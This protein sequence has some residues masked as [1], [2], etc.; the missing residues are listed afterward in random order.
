MPRVLGFLRQK[1][2]SRNNSFLTTNRTMFHQPLF[3]SRIVHASFH[4]STL[5]NEIIDERKIMLDDK[6]KVEEYIEHQ[7]KKR[8]TNQEKMQLIEEK[9][10]EAFIY[11]PEKPKDAL[12]VREKLSIKDKIMKEVMHYYDGFKLLYLDTKVAAKLLWRV[13]N[14]EVLLRR[15]KRQVG[16]FSH[17]LFFD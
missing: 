3:E 13:L 14:G 15:E 5:L 12:D 6:S 16:I 8:Q 17:F 4:T 2:S 1:L 11:K 9:L 7:R 10:Q